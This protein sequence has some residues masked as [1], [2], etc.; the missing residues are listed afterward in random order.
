MSREEEEKK[1]LEEFLGPV[2]T[3]ASNQAQDYDEL[4]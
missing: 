3:N 4:F 1:R 2:D